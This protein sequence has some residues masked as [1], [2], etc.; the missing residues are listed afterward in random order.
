MSQSD[1]TDTQNSKKVNHGRMILVILITLAVAAVIALAG[2]QG[3]ATY[4]FAGMNIPVLV[5]L[6]LIHI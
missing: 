5:L 4:P 2:S 3:G 1:T 6:S